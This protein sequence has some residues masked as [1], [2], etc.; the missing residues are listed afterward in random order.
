MLLNARMTSA[1]IVVAC[2]FA[3][4]LAAADVLISAD[5]IT[6][7]LEEFATGLGGDAM[8]VSPTDI[9]HMHDGSKRLAVSTITGVIRLLDGNGNY[10][11]SDT[12]PY[13]DMRGEPNR[14]TPG[15]FAFG[16]TGIVF[17]PD[18]AKQGYAGYGKFYTIQT[19]THQNNGNP[20]QPDLFDGLAQ[21]GGAHQDVLIE[22]TADD[23]ASNSPNWTRRTVV[24]MEQPHENHNVTDLA[25]GPDGN[26]YMA[27]GDGGSPNRFAAPQDVTTYIGKVLRID[28]LDPNAAGTRSTSGSYINS[29]NGEY[30][31]PMS[32]PGVGIPIEVEEVFAYG[33]R[34]PYRIG[35]DSETG[36]LYIGDVGESAKEEVSIVTL[37]SNLGWGRFEGTNERDAGIVL[38]GGSTHTPPVFEYGRSD[39]ETVVGGFVYH[40]SALP[41]LEGMY[42]FADFGRQVTGGQ[43]PSP[44]RLFYGDPDTGEI[45]EFNLDPMGE[46]LAEF[47]GSDLKSRQFIF[48]IGYDED[49]EIYLV[50][51]DD[52]QFPR[53]LLTDGRILRIVPE[54]ATL[55]L[56]M[57]IGGGMIV[58]RR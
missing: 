13:L 46:Q 24:R 28:P 29:G 14:F 55:L 52:P 2:V 32:N 31:I 56:A 12:N 58:R 18:F 40:G 38:V 43:A 51:G 44:A 47:V 5:N 23:P 48:S 16:T 57:G 34:S 20:N 26:L 17:H 21:A 6:V 10:L 54:P 3:L 8:H 11:D 22:W 35:F 41:E 30:R 19:E 15:N 36:D 45:F 33:L 25:F 39:G 50:V 4:D 49:G 42:I 53:A 9:V 1:I 7:Q 27:S 37:D